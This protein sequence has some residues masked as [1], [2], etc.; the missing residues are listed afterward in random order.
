MTAPADALKPFIRR[1]TLAY[2]VFLALMLL[3]PFR[4]SLDPAGKASR[5]GLN[6]VGADDGSLSVASA[7]NQCEVARQMKQRR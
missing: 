6:S 2:T 1:L 5:T 3:M 7:K 4:F